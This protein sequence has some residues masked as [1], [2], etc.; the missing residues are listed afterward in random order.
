MNYGSGSKKIYFFMLNCQVEWKDN[1]EFNRTRC[2][3]IFRKYNKNEGIKKKYEN[4]LIILII[5]VD[6]FNT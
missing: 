1:G 3:S 6:D 4:E 2:W 5:N